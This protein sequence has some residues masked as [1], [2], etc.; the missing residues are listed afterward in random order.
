MFNEIMLGSPASTQRASPW[1]RADRRT[2]SCISKLAT[3]DNKIDAVAGRLEAKIDASRVHVEMMLWKHTTGI[4]GRVLAAGGG[5]L[6][7]ML[8]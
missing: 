1:T 2:A 5:L 3:A 7:R 8:R 4:I 6:L